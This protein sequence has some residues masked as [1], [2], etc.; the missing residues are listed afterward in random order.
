MKSNQ[1]LKNVIPTEKGVLLVESTNAL[2]FKVDKKA[3]KKTIKESVEKALDV[4]VDAV[5]TQNT[6]HN[7]KKAYVKLHKDHMAIDVMTK[8][9]LM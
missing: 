7:Y 4:K 8:L 9:G 6:C 3:N 1:I 5:R 2:V